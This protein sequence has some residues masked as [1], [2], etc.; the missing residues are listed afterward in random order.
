MTLMGATS[1]S[2]YNHSTRSLHH[3]LQHKTQALIV[4]YIHFYFIILMTQNNSVP[5]SVGHIL[6]Y[7][8]GDTIKSMPHCLFK[9]TSGLAV[10]LCNS[11]LYIFVG[12]TRHCGHPVQ[13]GPETIQVC[14]C[15]SE[16]TS[17]MQDI[18]IKGENVF[19][20]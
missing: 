6:E 12:V 14:A 20:L 18:L 1:Y 2:R 17:V 9:V 13:S 4:Q 5:Y 11:L 3:I 15:L 8:W 10:L 19:T 16:S 7:L